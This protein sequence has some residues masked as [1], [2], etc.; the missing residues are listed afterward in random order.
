[1]PTITATD[2]RVSKLVTLGVT[3]ADAVL[4][5]A[6]GYTTPAI[7]RATEDADLLEVIES[8]SELARWRPEES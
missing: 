4:L 8:L 7:I 1:M 3:T 2:P 5:V 6:A